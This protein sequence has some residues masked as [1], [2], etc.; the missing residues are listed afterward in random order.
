ME[1]EAVL[2]SLDSCKLAVLTVN[3][4]NSH[5]EALAID[6]YIGVLSKQDANI[7]STVVRN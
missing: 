7:H 4:F 3:D 2:R 1:A 5:C 6:F